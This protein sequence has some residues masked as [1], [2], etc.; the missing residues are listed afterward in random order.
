[1]LNRVGHWMAD[2]CYLL[3][4]RGGGPQI[5]QITLRSGNIRRITFEGEYNARASFSA[6]GKMINGT[7]SYTRIV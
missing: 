4:D 5:Y 1:M 3:P 6:D 2:R 7:Q